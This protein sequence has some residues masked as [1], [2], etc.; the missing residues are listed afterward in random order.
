MRRLVWTGLLSCAFLTVSMHAAT[1]LLDGWRLQSACN[2]NAGGKA[3]SAPNF[4][5][6]D[7]LATSVPNTVVAAQV[8]AHVLP[9]PYFADNLRKL[10]GMTYPVAKN[11]SNLP[12][13][14][15]SPYHCGW[16]YRKQFTAPAAGKDGHYW[17]HFGGINYRANI[18]VNGQQIADTSQIAGAYRIYDLDVTRA[19]KPGMANAVAVEVF[20]PTE[21]DLGINWVDWNPAP[22]DKDMG[23]WGDVELSTTGPV[24]L[25]APMVV[26]HFNDETLGSAELTVHAEVRNASD[27]K[28][29]G[30]VAGSA[31]GIAFQ[32][33]V[34]L[35]PHETR[36][37][38]FAP[39]QFPQLHVRNPKVWW[40]RQMGTPHLERLAV[41]FE[42]DGQLSDE[43]SVE[44]GIREITSELTA[45]GARLY[46]VNGKP[47]LIRGAG[48]TQDML[49]R[50][51]PE[52]LAKEFALVRDLNLNTLRLEGKME[53]DAFFRL[54]DREGILVMA[55]W[56]C[57]D[58]W[59][60]WETWSAESHTV[61]NESLR[62]QMLRLRH[63]PSLFVWLHGSDKP[64]P[65]DVERDYLAVEADVRWPNPVLPSA[66][67]LPSKV[68]GESGVKMTGPYDFVEPSYWYQDTANGGNF[69]F[70]TETGPGPSIPSL[71]SRKKF[72]SD[73]EAWPPSET[74]R[75][76][77]GNEDFSTFNVLNDA[78]NSIY[79]K[80][81]SLAEYERLA[82]TMEYDSQRAMFESYSANKYTSTGV[83][84]WL[85]NN[86]WPSMIWHLYDYNL[87]PGSNYY[88]AKK[89]N[90]P[91]HIQY[92][93][94]DRSIVVVN[95]TYRAVGGLK[96]SVDVRDLQWNQLFTAT[97]PA[98]LSPDAVVQVFRIPE[99]LYSDKQ[100]VLFVDLKLTDSAGA[101]VSRN[102]YWVP[103]PLTTF[104][105]PATTYFYTPSS[106]YPDLS[107][108]KH[109]SAAT[110]TAQSEIAATTNGR[111]IKVHL[112][113][114][115][116]APAFQIN[117]AVETPT[118]GLVA[119]V[120][121][122]DNWITLTPGESRT[123]TAML[124]KGT[125][126]V[127]VKMNA[128][129]VAPATLALAGK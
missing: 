79:G 118:G 61:A 18:W 77:Y 117:M 108:L 102:F 74:W 34:E 39:R 14:P 84:Q 66:H 60:K 125:G 40:P 95:S 75:L 76:H 45:K 21:H 9:D 78:M 98:N 35:A 124:P 58:V 113:N 64:P 54:A 3:I 123:L 55:G 33:P 114:T 15:D 90:E 115:S 27:R 88:A 120:M 85:L 47:I 127:V 111:E 7:W 22:P 128:W 56:C 65:A 81:G 63:H 43:K 29:H 70:N 72:L 38:T 10:P 5:A 73:P 30:V 87:D 99:T 122:S 92:S 16:W 12:M 32:Q 57:C 89:A 86:S 96:A 6:A 51:D 116:N 26:T 37:V 103:Y 100:K 19:I 83:I 46:R 2:I 23:L 11:F 52:R 59:E 68:L 41:R 101:V 13:S 20:A 80:P 126:D 112:T 82:A 1:P 62:S 106:R 119:P 53:T 71:A 69:G 17:L 129:N 42:I 8:G 25:S 50:S 28:V 121:W 31:G 93:Y 67:F 104:K 107:A 109:L 48:W 4:T 94:T 36:T 110:V 97:A 24:A 105:W 49:L 44:F 91:V